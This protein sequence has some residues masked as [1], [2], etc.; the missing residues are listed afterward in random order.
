MSMTSSCKRTGYTNSAKQ[1][2]HDSLAS[3][4]KLISE[5]ELPNVKGGF[6]LM[7]VDEKNKRLF[8][9]AEDNHTVEVADL[10]H[11]RPIKTIT[12][13]N[14]PKWI[15]YLPEL[16]SV[17]IS[18]GADARV[19]ELD[20]SSY[21][22]KHVF[23]FKEKC[24]NLRYDTS[25]HLLFV[26]VGKTFGSIGI[27]DVMQSKIVYQIPLAAYPKQFEVTDK[28]IYVNVPEMGLVQI[29]D[30]ASQKV[31]SDI[32]VTAN[33]D[34][35]PMAL[36]REHERLFIG[37]QKGKLLVYS[38]QTRKQVASIAIKL[39]VDGIYYDPKRKQLYLSCGEGYVEVL[40]QTDA[41]H[42]K[43]LDCQATAAGAATSLYSTRLDKLFLAVPQSK[44][45]GASI[46]IYQ[47]K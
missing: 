39:D 33:R 19:T 44:E 32:T 21:R 5:I 27:I 16:R 14:E 25:V 38:T 41:D 28:L 17:F 34:N 3:N 6:D 24:N 15:V 42:Y 13:L 20:D 7:A 4:L 43:L 26:G 35:V 23:S 12:D 30:R 45:H 8:V 1:E 18:T 31:I 2:I 36:D 46:R 40:K 47:P 10:T 37:S 9:S 22:I 29:I 11:N